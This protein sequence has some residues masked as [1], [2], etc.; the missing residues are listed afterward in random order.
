MGPYLS[1]VIPAFNEETN[2]RAGA[3][4]KVAAYLDRQPYSYEV[5]VVDDGSE[6]AT[7]ELAEAFAT[8]HPH[9]RLQRNPHQGKAHT[10]ISGVLA[11]QGDLV[12]FTD[13]DQATPICEAA[14]LLPWFEQGYD[15]VFGSRGIHRRGAPWWRTL[16]S[17]GMIVLRGLIVNLPD[18]TDTQCGFK[19]FRGSVARDTFRHMHLYAPGRD[20][21]VR[22][23]VVAAGF[24][25]ETLF[26]ARKLGY[27]IK[28]VPVNWDYARTRRVSFWLDSL[29][30]L[31][32]LIRIRYNDLR[33]HYAGRG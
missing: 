20:P 21:R 12:L 9:F 15:V 24:D 27:R 2:L 10:V 30:G 18:I 11:A 6:D 1:V 19:A 25:V 14:S 17:R 13:M 3:L 23:A 22:G 26:V 31:R 16:M 5:L 7:A 29:R 4:E 33:G 8:Q 28:E 32:D